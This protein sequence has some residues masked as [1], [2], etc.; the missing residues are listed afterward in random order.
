MSVWV[1]KLE[2]GTIKSELIAPEHLTAQMSVGWVVDKSQL[3]KEL[4]G[5]NNPKASLKIDDLRK[6]A[7]EAGIEGWDTKRSAT[8]IKELEALN[9]ADQN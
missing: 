7:K 5:A 2:E 6:K 9:N 4:N 1:Y 8:L 3:E